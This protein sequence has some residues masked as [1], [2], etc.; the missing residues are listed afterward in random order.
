MTHAN[1]S[2]FSPRRQHWVSR[3]DFY[4]R[5][6]FLAVVIVALVLKFIAAGR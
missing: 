1:R 5:L 3:V 4:V 6:A 2:A